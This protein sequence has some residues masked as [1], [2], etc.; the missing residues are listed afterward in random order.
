MKAKR[1]AGLVTAVVAA[2]W[3]PLICWAE[4]NSG[5]NGS[6]GAFNPTTN[7][8]VNMADHPNGIYQF[9]SVN[10]PSGVTVTFTPNASNTP[11]L[12]LVQSNCTINGSVDASGG[13]C[14]SP[15][16]GVAGVGGWRGGNGGDGNRDGLGPGGGGGESGYY[17]ASSGA[18]YATVGA[19][20]RPGVSYG[21]GFL[22]PLMGGSGGGGMRT[23]G[24]AGGGGGGVILI[25]ASAF[26]AVNGSISANGGNG[27]GH[28]DSSYGSVGSGGGSGGGVRLVA[29][30]I[31]GSGSIS[32]GGGG[33]WC[34]R[35][36]GSGR[37]RFDTLD[38]SFAGSLSGSFTQG[39]QPVIIPTAG[40][41][42]QLVIASVGGVAVSSSPTG[43]LSVPDAV[44]S[45]H[46]E[47]PIPVVVRCSNLPLNTPITVSVRPANGAVATG[48]GYN[49]IGTQASSTATML[50][51][52][53]RG[54]GMIWAA[55]TTGN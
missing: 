44:I 51:S 11:V 27:G 3:L 25:A 26:I 13:Q 7:T 15:V 9:T 16:G 42:V 5:S 19:G 20:S 1:Y 2:V 30:M 14:N 29:G 50:V 8:V 43:V 41:G 39:L 33:G 54:G 49:N 23:P 48:L 40:Q 4:V 17:T 34:V 47:N 31:Q 45:P 6:D 53:P 55:A 35:S 12:W 46:Q 37:I 24:Y 22:L 28:F 52:I 10:I 38:N 32:A 36:G 18:S 21:N